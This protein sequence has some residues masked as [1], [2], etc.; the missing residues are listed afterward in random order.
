M[1]ALLVS[2]DTTFLG[3]VPDREMP[4]TEFREGT[5]REHAYSY[6]EDVY[7]V[8]EAILDESLDEPTLARYLHAAGGAFLHGHLGHGLRELRKAGCDHLVVVPHG[9][10]HFAPLHLFETDGRLLADDWTVSVLP[11]LELLFREPASPTAR[12]GT[13]AFGL[14]FDTFNPHRLPALEDAPDEARRIAELTGG[15]AW[16]DAQATEPAVHDAL[17]T[18]RHVHLATHGALN[19]D[20]PAFQVLVVAPDATHDGLIHAHEL[21]GP[22]QDLDGLELVTLGAC[23][24]A[25]GRVDRADNPRGLPAAFL[26]AGARAVI[27]TLWNVA[28]DA[29]RA[30]FVAL[31]GALGGGL[32]P[33][34]A[35]RVA[36]REV[37]RRFP[38][39]RDWGAFYFLGA[40]SGA[41]LAQPV[42][43]PNPTLAEAP[44][45]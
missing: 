39:P 6:E 23:E 44:S 9:P 2:A 28:G 31:Y 18:A 17:R 5:R 27:G 11:S 34:E 20:A 1:V 22:G 19:L 14:G 4:L 40:G 24:T 43:P 35:F 29:S 37:R 42:P 32:P 33:V 38:H 13:V 16:I 45:A 25:L 8:R 3:A 30:F 12:Q 7:L 15:L 21:L 26:L 10:F 41:T 36:Q